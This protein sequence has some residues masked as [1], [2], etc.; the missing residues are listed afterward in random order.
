MLLTVVFLFGGL[1]S[2]VVISYKEGII[3]R[4]Y[5]I[6]KSIPISGHQNT[7]YTRITMC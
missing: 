1:V 3:A 4:D 5:A 7:T 6:V 2:M